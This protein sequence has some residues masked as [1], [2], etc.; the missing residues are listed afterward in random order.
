VKPAIFSD[1]FDLK[2]FVLVLKAEAAEALSFK[3]GVYA[4]GGMIWFCGTSL[5][6]MEF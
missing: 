2:F 4:A 6:R 1:S 5:L 3:E